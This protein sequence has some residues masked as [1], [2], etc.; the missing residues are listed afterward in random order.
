MF[1]WYTYVDDPRARVVAE[2]VASEVNRE[3]GVVLASYGCGWTFLQ[4]S[5]FGMRGMP[6]VEGGEDTPAASK[7]AAS[8]VYKGS[9]RSLCVGDEAL[10]HLEEVS[11]GKAVLKYR[12]VQHHAL[13]K[14]KH[15]LRENEIVG[16]RDVI[17]GLSMRPILQYAQAV[18]QERRPRQHSPSEIHKRAAVFG[19]TMTLASAVQRGRRDDDSGSDADSTGSFKLRHV[20]SSAAWIGVPRTVRLAPTICL[21]VSRLLVRLQDCVEL[22]SALKKHFD[23]S[24]DVDETPLDALRRLQGRA[25]DGGPASTTEREALKTLALTEPLTCRFKV[26]ERRLR[27]C[28]HNG[29]TLSDLGVSVILGERERTLAE[30]EGNQAPVTELFPL[31]AR[32]GEDKHLALSL[33]RFCRS[34]HMALVF[35]LEYAVRPDQSGRRLPAPIN[36]G[37]DFTD[38]DGQGDGYLTKHSQVATVV[39]G[40]AACLPFDG[41]KLRLR[42]SM[43]PRLLVATD[44]A[45]GRF[46]LP[47][48]VTAVSHTVASQL[49]GTP[50][51]WP[52]PGVDDLYDGDRS[53]DRDKPLRLVRFR[54]DA[55]DR[56]GRPLKDET[57]HDPME[58]EEE[59]EWGEGEGKDG[60]SDSDDDKVVDGDGNSS[61][62]GISEDD[63]EDDI[64]TSGDEDG[65][66]DYA[67]G[68]EDYDDAPRFRSRRAKHHSRK[69]ASARR[70]KFARGIDRTHLNSTVRPR[71]N[72][73]LD[74]V[75]PRSD[76]SL[77]SALDHHQPPGRTNRTNLGV[78]FDALP[79]HGSSAP[80]DPD[81]AKTL[82][83]E[84]LGASS[85]LGHALSAPLGRDFS[86]YD[87]KQSGPE[88][89]PSLDHAKMAP[90][91]S[92]SFFGA[93]TMGRLEETSFVDPGISRASRARLGQ[94]GAMGKGAAADC[95]AFMP[96]GRALVV[97]TELT[98]P[99]CLNVLTLR[100]AA[101]RSPDKTSPLPRVVTFSY[102]FF[103]RPPTRSARAVLNLDVGAVSSDVSNT[104]PRVLVA[105]EDSP[106][107]SLG[108]RYGSAPEEK[109]VFD[110]SLVT[111]AEAQG[112]FTYLASRSMFIDVW[113]G[114]SL[115]HLG[116]VALP[117][118]PFLR[119]GR[120]LAQHAKEYD[121]VAPFG[122]LP[123]G[124]TTIPGRNESIEGAIVGK[125]QLVGV[126]YGDAGKG[127]HPGAEG[128]VPPSR[129]PQPD[130]GTS[131]NWRFGV[132]GNGGDEA[133]PDRPTFRK[134][135]RPMVVANQETGQA[136]LALTK[137]HL[138]RSAV[139]KSGEG[140]ALSYEEVLL[141]AKRFADVSEGRKGCV[142]YKGRLLELLD[143]PSLEV[144]EQR[145]VADLTRLED[146]GRSLGKLM[147]LLDRCGDSSVRFAD[148]M[149][150]LRS[151]C[152]GTF[153]RLKEREAKLLVGRMIGDSSGVVSVEALV[154]WVQA[155][156]NTGATITALQRLVTKAEVKLGVDNCDV[157]AA[158]VMED[159]ESVSV[160]NFVRGV[161]VLQQNLGLSS[162]IE[163]KNLADSQLARVARGLNSAGRGR[164]SLKVFMKKLG[165][166]FT[167]FAG[168]VRVALRELVQ[169]GASIEE[170]FG[171]WDDNNTGVVSPA[172]LVACLGLKCTPSAV[173][174]AAALSSSG[175][176]GLTMS[177]VFCGAGLSF[178]AHLRERLATTLQLA[179]QR[180]PLDQVFAT[181]NR[182]GSG[183]LS[184][185]E[186]LDGLRG[187]GTPLM[188]HL[189]TDDATTLLRGMGG[190]RLADLVGV[191]GKDPDALL[192]AKLRRVLL[193][194]EDSG[195]SIHTRFREWD[196]DGSGMLSLAEL[197]SGFDQLAIFEENCLDRAEVRTLLG[198]LSSCGAD[199]VHFR[200]L[201]ALLGRNFGSYAEARLHN[202]VASAN[203]D[204][205]PLFQALDSDGDGYA[206]S[207][208]LESGLKQIVGFEDV[209]RQEVD[210]IVA[211]HD[212]SGSGGSIDLDEL[213][214]ILGQRFKAKD[215][216]ARAANKLLARCRATS[217]PPA[218]LGQRFA[219]S[220]DAQ[221]EGAVSVRTL[222]SGL[223]SFG[224]SRQDAA[225]LASALA[226]AGADSEQVTRAAWL[227]FCE[228][229]GLLTEAEAA[230]AEHAARTA[231]QVSPVASMSLRPDSIQ[232]S[233]KAVEGEGG[234]R[235]GER[236][237]ASSEIKGAEEEDATNLARA[238]AGNAAS[239]SEYTFSADPS[240][241]AIERKL[242]RVAQSFQ[243]RVERGGGGCDVEGLFQAYD[244]KGTGSVLRSEFVNVL[245]QLGLSLLDIPTGAGG[246]G[247]GA[248]EDEAAERRRRLAQLTRVKGADLEKRTVRLRARQPG[249]LG[250]AEAGDGSEELALLK[251][252]REGCKK[253]MVR[254]LV[255][256]GVKAEYHVVSRFGETV[257]FEHQVTNPFGHEERLRV[258]L[259]ASRPD[260]RLVTSVDEWA[261]L[262]AHCPPPPG[263]PPLCAAGP[264][265]DF[266]ALDKEGAQLWVSAR[267]TVAV[268][269]AF[270]RLSAPGRTARDDEEHCIVVRIV[271]VAHGLV[272]GL[273]HVHVHPRP[274]VIHRTLRFHDAEGGIVKR[275]VLLHGRSRHLFVPV[276]GDGSRHVL[277]ESRLSSDGRDSVELRLKYSKI[278]PFPSSGDFYLL[279][280]VDPFK[281][282]VD[283]IWHVVLSSR[284]RKDVHA[285][286]GCSSAAELVVR[287]DR[288]GSRRVMAF[289]SNEPEVSFDPNGPFGLAP[290]A[291]NRLSLRWAP[292]GVAGTRVAHVHLV[293]A[294]TRQLV[295]AW[296]LTCVASPPEVTRELDAEVV[297]GTP[298][299]KKVQL[300]NPWGRPQT[301]RLRSSDHSVMRPKQDRVTLEPH[302]SIYLRLYLAAP[303]S[304]GVSEVFLLVN[305]ESDQLDE[306]F[307]I[308]IRAEW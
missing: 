214:K 292:C 300:T 7:V 130:P 273:L 77:D 44:H 197:E 144:A 143:V 215:V 255:E 55:E 86:F 58:E 261:H 1:L 175:E 102:R 16:S 73:A 299:H 174:E 284:L 57:P 129:S 62:M 122:D 93:Q 127:S 203:V 97:R 50:L 117:L 206:T 17:P 76:Q 47:L 244:K 231:V 116:T 148:L 281:S 98:D 167:P 110:T 140:N 182:S 78:S 282:I 120:P 103:D 142:A 96:S 253:S 248:M 307:R 216:V 51:V 111:A 180:A 32:G 85:L 15:L 252:Y 241:A 293:D 21:K 36:D 249:L 75:S 12:V 229:R 160:D 187:L 100:F 191:V 254:K 242:R 258:E 26:L 225:G 88:F 236:D 151:L 132:S 118:H 224:L 155:R 163:S 275:S 123:G 138:E 67:S 125:L 64:E 147:T 72:D 5:P 69:N 185:Q 83:S 219:N 49:P 188:L 63:D 193:A 198:T 87:G 247:D 171:S 90:L 53:V 20:A 296:L 250:A 181:W 31:L 270:T 213:A 290:N 114:D 13:L 128:P 146:G 37:I 60:D 179:E 226:G 115:L 80:K 277:V 30:N 43:D 2:L 209:S 94:G 288:Q 217:M 195:V 113:D 230:A 8:P 145:M 235:S 266:L 271:S 24:L 294:D 304:A 301:Y 173:A 274:P 74:L 218:D 194:T 84:P 264:E 212:V 222:M 256:S 232:R 104:T 126:C 136:S 265:V 202:A 92:S 101:Y 245:M 283:E 233:P 306:C 79:L 133:R 297:V 287:G 279:S 42:G 243:A 240:T 262:R 91:M 139:P 38:G 68:K 65:V 95:S 190:G 269:L 221:G 308:V 201:M 106:G 149:D 210:E 267:E 28:L 40:S 227:Q 208:E 109:I 18:P 220:W 184:A 298:A 48:V 25:G 99:K 59:A 34:R 278:G 178:D 66:R 272:V 251:W 172:D 4:P 166:T 280:Y 186:L 192:A 156:Q 108:R 29:H 205:Q 70:R 170:L 285:P 121:V 3:H 154:S 228:R 207:E 259:D 23:W 239:S 45:S 112:F 161:R 211:R 33:P 6:S 150:G 134:R 10:D 196:K 152:P 11:G 257:F 19:S 223:L 295:A 263:L 165:K 89:A 276:E 158:N 54:C 135:S 200:D 289:A 189:T 159:G 14:A 82:L 286:L 153:G 157:W 35:I 27:V 234:A 302:G 177:D 52:Q 238:T 268:P 176:A 291:F 107:A 39:L 124:A 168:G 56:E 105:E 141:A 81:A 260:L 164:V 246:G 305:D 71:S 204:L 169:A 183:S 9:P 131:L 237:D 46:A 119:Q 137:G 162:S 22:E 199:S 61:D 303:Q 41:S